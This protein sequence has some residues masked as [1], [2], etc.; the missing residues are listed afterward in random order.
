MSRETLQIFY[1]HVFRTWTAVV[2]TLSLPWYR[3]GE[4]IKRIL[5]LILMEGHPEMKRSF[6][7]S[8]LFS[9]LGFQPAHASSEQCFQFF[10]NDL[11]EWAHRETWC[12]QERRIESQVYL[13]LFQFDSGFADLVKP[14]LTALIKLDHKKRP[15]K[16]SVGSNHRG[17]VQFDE[18]PS[19]KLNPFAIPLSPEEASQV[20]VRV[21][22]HTRKA[23][24][25]LDSFIS[26]H[27][28]QVRAHS[29]ISLQEG[30]YSANIS[31][32]HFPF[33]GFWW[34]LAGLPMSSGPNSPLGFYDLYQKAHTGRNPN[35]VGWEEK[36]HTG[37]EAEWGGHCNGWAASSVLFP[38]PTKTLYDPTT[39]RVLTPYAQKGML[40]EA[41]Y[42]VQ[43]AFYGKRYS[44][45]GDDLLD[46]YPDVFHRVLSYYIGE[47]GQGVAM[48]YVRTAEIDNHTITGY[49]FEIRANGL[50]SYHVNAVLTV[51]G[52]D[53]EQR[54]SIGRAVT[55]ERKYSYTLKTDAKGEIISGQ[56]DESSDNPDFLWVALSPA[57]NCGGMNPKIDYQTVSKIIQSL[58]EAKVT[59]SNPNIRVVASLYPQLQIPLATL[60][61]MGDGIE[62]TYTV[63]SVSTA[64]LQLI[65][66]GNARYP[67]KGGIDES[68]FIPVTVGTHVAKL[69]RLLSI[70]NAVVVNSS[71]QNTVTLD[72]SVDRVQFYK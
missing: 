8:F 39:G 49:R 38:E 36:N 47:L 16:M 60:I 18:L 48:D 12:Y 23:S 14:E 63:N 29:V 21:Y 69:D 42:C 72:M 56:W 45:P 5:D 68:V 71:T 35:S 4:K 22:P 54:D 24:A 3:C 51:A 1:K 65:F 43:T 44:G 10:K 26:S 17:T 58:P 41:A 50:Q 25:L 20:A 57:K 40:A 11:P 15:L 33:N 31:E 70:S 32:K 27:R 67:I 28:V 46:V 59:S 37:G 19:L 7:F 66:S 9:I 52:Y 2:K 6:L 34:S 13:F 61:P 30:I 55:Y 53:I 64:G 62:I